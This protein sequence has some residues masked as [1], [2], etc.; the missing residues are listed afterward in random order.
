MVDGLQ[1]GS[2]YFMSFFFS[3]QILKVEQTKN[4]VFN[5]NEKKNEK[6]TKNKNRRKTHPNSLHL[7]LLMSMREVKC[8]KAHLQHTVKLQPRQNNLRVE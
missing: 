2:L 1:K 7:L 6:F 3:K 5:Q 8:K 4:R